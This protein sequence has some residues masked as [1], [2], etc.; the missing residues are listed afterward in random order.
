LPQA[1]QFAGSLFVGMQTPP[2]FEKPG[3][4]AKSQVPP[5][6]D[7]TA[8]AGTGQAVPQAPQCARFERV[9]TQAPPQGVSPAPQA[10]R[11]APFEHT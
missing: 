11:H 2:H 6:H 3:L 9:S 1:P 8:W 4:H 10:A 7:A 5:V